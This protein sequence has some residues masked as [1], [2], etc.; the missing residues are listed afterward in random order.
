M[1]ELYLFG[2]R[3]RG[4][5][6]PN[7]DIDVFIDSVNLTGVRLRMIVNLLRPYAVEYG[8]KLDLFEL[9]GDDLIPPFD[10]HDCRRVIL[11]K[12]SFKDLQ[13]EAKPITLMELVQLIGGA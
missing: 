2:S 9:H 11:N 5:H 12:W 8:G 4:D 13:A 1:S 6:K 10:V 7:S 3:A